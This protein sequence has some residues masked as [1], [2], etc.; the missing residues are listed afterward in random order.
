MNN[1]CN[2]N[3]DKLNYTGH[4]K[5]RYGQLGNKLLFFWRHRAASSGV[6]IA[7]SP[8]KHTYYFLDTTGHEYYT[9]TCQPDNDKVLQNVN[10]T[11]I[12][13]CVANCVARPQQGLISIEFLA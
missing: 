8:L 2:L 1:L 13:N 7:L 9:A 5:D 12:A 3:F 10:I 4:Q 11:S 6:S